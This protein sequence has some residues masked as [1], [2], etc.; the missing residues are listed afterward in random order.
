MGSQAMLN[1]VNWVRQMTLAKI[2]SIDEHLFDVQPA[3]FNNTIRWNIGHIVSSQNALVFTRIDQK[4][5]LPEAFIDLFKGGTRPSEWT[6][7]APSKAELIDLL[8]KQLQDI[9]D[10][11][12]NRI[13]DPLPSPF[14]IR[15]F[16][17]K[18]VGDAIGFSVI[19]EAQHL[20][21]INDLLK[22]IQHQS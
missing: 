20:A 21:V 6:S 10:T 9:N 16:D 22:A 7:P 11:Y 19:H 12:G 17:F 1:T 5:L 13:D 15:V 3:P 4:S 8:K 14:Q 2:E 18:T